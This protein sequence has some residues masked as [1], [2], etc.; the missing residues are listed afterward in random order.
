M[1]IRALSIHGHF[2]QPPREDPVSGVIPSEYGASP[3]R[4]WNERIHA[5]CYLPNAK[6]GN[7]EKISFNIG[8][9]LLSWMNGYD[10]S[11]TRLIV[12]QDRVNLHQYGVGNAIAQ[13]YNHT[14]L[15]LATYEDKVTQV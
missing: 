11:A 14:I 9:T 8:P 10:P 2:Y 1:S 3:Y 15:P 12:A 4:N 13:A 6:L 7:F 5:E